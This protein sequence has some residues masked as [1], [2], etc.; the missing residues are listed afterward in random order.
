MN[1]YIL[2]DCDAKSDRCFGKHFQTIGLSV[3]HSPY[4]NIVHMA[5]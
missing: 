4:Y 2:C 1:V 5:Q 3:A